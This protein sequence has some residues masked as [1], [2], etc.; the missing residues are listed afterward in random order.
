VRRRL[1]AELVRRG[2]ASSRARATEAINAGRVLVRGLP[3]HTAAHQVAQHDPITLAGPPPR[4]VS[5]GG[6][7]LDGALDRFPVAVAG[8]RALDA[9]ASTGGFTDCLLQHGAELVHAV[10]VGRG[11]LAW[12]LRQDPRVVVHDRTNV[13]DLDV[14]I[15]GGA[16]DL[17]VADLSFIS[18]TVVAPALARAAT[19]TADFVLLVKPQFEAGRAR[20]GKGG[21]VRDPAVHADVLVSTARSLAAHGLAVIGACVASPLG[22]TGNREFFVHADRHGPSLGDAELAAV[23][24]PA[25]ARDLERDV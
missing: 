13:R 24:E 3:A 10:D 22:A 2:L 17:V 11:Q 20:V 15:L 16:V 8:R 23:A 9:G 18:L 1:D 4:F 6:E 12:S 19:S 14:A 7:K 21:V 5:R 25:P